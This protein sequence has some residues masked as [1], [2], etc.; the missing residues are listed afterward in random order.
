VRVKYRLKADPSIP[1]QVVV[2]QPLA[3]VSR[4]AALTPTEKRSRHV[5]QQRRLFNALQLYYAPNV[6]IDETLHQWAEAARRR[7]ER[8]KQARLSRGSAPG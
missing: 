7:R 6:I 3:S 8:H 4:Y 1:Y 2:V 5:R